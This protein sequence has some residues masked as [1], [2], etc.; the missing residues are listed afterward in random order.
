[1]AAAL[2]ALLH[3]DAQAAPASRRR[4]RLALPLDRLLVVC[5]LAFVVIVVP[6][7]APALFP[8]PTTI[9]PEAEAAF[10]L[11]EAAP[12]DKPVLVAFDYEPAHQ[13]EM[14]PPAQA[15]LAHLMRRGVPLVAVSTR[16]A[17]APVADEVLNELALGHG[18]VYGANFVNLG[19]IPGG[20]VGL[21]QFAANPRSLFSAD[22]RGTRDVWN[23][24]AARHVN[25]LGDVGLIVLV[26]A[27]PDDTRAWVEQ[28]QRYAAGVPTVAVVSAGAAPLVRP[29]YETDPRQISAMVTGII[30]AAQYEQRAGA[31]GAASLRWNAMNGGLITAAA[32][33]LAGN[34][35][36]GA[37]HVL[38]RVRFQRR[39]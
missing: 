2:T 34:L 27:T 8:L 38:R 12:L 17:G 24:P 7:A 16:A 25:G 1:M 30:G 18:Y 15:L 10:Q 20:P 3:E 14:N 9:A 35:I 13:G 22:F 4:F 19:Y 11:I 36:Y 6:V 26:S 33:I 28:T 29:Y 31:P 32:L 39:K 23:Q 5:L 37:L 21:L